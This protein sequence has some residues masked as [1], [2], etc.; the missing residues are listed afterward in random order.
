MARN[1]RIRGIGRVVLLLIG[2]I[3]IFLLANSAVSAARDLGKRL[4]L[5]PLRQEQSAVF[6]ATATAIGFINAT[7]HS[8]QTRLP[9]ATRTPT[10]IEGGFAPESTTGVTSAA[11]RASDLPAETPAPTVTPGEPPTNTPTLSPTPQQV[12]L[13]STVLPTNTRRP[14]RTPTPE[15][16]TAT[17]TFTATPTEPPTGTPT[18]S[19]SAT[20]TTTSAPTT[21]VPT[22]AATSKLPV[23]PARSECT[24][25][26][27]PTA[28]PTPAPRVKANGNDIMNI[29]LIGSDAD[30]DPT[31]PSFRTDTMVIVSI[32]RTANS[33]AM[34]SI[35]RDLY[36][37][38]PQLGMQRINVAY[39]WGESVKW[40]PGG[41]FGLLQETILYNLGIPVH[42]YA[43]VSF[44]GFKSIIDTLKGVDVAV[45][46]P[47]RNELRFQGSYN[48]LKT[49]IY[50]PF[51]LE[52]GYYRMDAS[53]ALWY[54]R[55]RQ[56]TSDFD[57]NR[58][59]QQI[60]RAIWREARAQGL[61]QKAPELWGQVTSLVQTNLTL[62]DVLGL[63]PIA[64]NLNPEDITNYYM[65]KGLETQHWKT[66]N[67]E[68]VQIPNPE[69]MFKTIRD[70]YTPPT[71]NRL[72]REAATIEIQNGAAGKDWD[73][74]AADTL[75]WKGLGAQAKGTGS[76]SAR[77][78]IY[79]FTGN[80][81][82]GTRTTIA[83][84]LNVRADAVIGQPDPNRAVDFRI[85]LGED[86][87]SCT[88]PGFG[89]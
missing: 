14:S 82:P 72:G 43:R 22:L 66:P 41:G 2:L 67:A 17:P 70:F 85:V 28:V 42:Y 75:S 76:P 49:P 71:K 30:L 12:A 86:Y 79:D 18:M 25:K 23:V 34:L 7:L 4:A 20:A 45:D 32:N 62:A 24:N 61:I 74:V 57:R 87:N 55:M 80:A 1:R 89:K 51:S 15:A 64:L 53:L 27:Q 29:L 38:I 40:S 44:T 19:P 68:D 58:R 56:T 60:L 39:Q 81:K 31:D 10:P 33:V 83:R 35:A 69:I 3:L 36:V 11:L 16:A 59:Q 77:T 26:P 47:I 6:P 8:E 48:D 63:V 88:A 73:K 5:R 21:S 50:A 52:V 84:A 9:A 37:C 46:C 65:V 78:M 13:Q 54:A